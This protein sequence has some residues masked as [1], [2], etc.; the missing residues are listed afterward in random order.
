MSPFALLSLLATGY[1][2]PHAPRLAP[3]A[4]GRAAAAA[5]RAPADHDVD[6]AV[7]GGGPAGYAMA[8]LLASKHGHSVAL[9]D[10]SPE[11]AWPNNYGSW[12]VE[13]EALSRRLEMPELLSACVAEEWAVTDCYFGG[14]YGT[15]WGERTRLDKAYVQVDR[16][17]LK[18]ALAA[19]LASAPTPAVVLGASLRAR[20]V[21]PN[22]FDS[23][24]EHD[25]SGSSLALDD[26]TTVR[27]RTVVDATGFESK[28]VARETDEAA[29]LW[30]PLPPGYQIAYGFSVDVKGGHAPYAPEVR[31]AQPAP[32]RRPPPARQR[33]RPARRASPSPPP[34]PLPPAA[35]RRRR[36]RR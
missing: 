8:A 31:G 18:A 20:T 15:E 34:R 5:L 9:V 10:P 6:V 7:I 23:N 2:A 32:R 17:A 3:R 13:W 11:G 28:L 30:K 26:G 27:A 36:R 22:L 4:P 21:A 25:A 12:R 29:G 19:K 16:A 24:L 33:A 35:T 1:L 14:S